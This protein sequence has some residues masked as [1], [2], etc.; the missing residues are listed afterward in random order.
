MGGAVVLL[1]GHDGGRRRELRGEVQDVAHLGSPEAIDRLGI[2]ANHGEA[3]AVR[4]QA[5][6][7]GGLQGVG[8]LVLVDQDVVE[9][10]AHLGGQ[11]RHLHQLAPVEQQVVVIEHL[12]FLLGL[13]IGL[14]QSRP[15]RPSIPRTR[16]SA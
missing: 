1:Q 11:L 14:E 10:A 12:L 3:A 7:D 2:V 15:G 9:K 16:G 5:K 8:V 4:L 6:Q 13:D